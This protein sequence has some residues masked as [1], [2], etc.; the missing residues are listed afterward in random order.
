MHRWIL[1][2]VVAA[3]ACSSAL[4]QVQVTGAWVR[5]TA[6]AQKTTGAYLELTSTRGATLVG[7]E[8]ADAALAEIHEMRMEGNVM[9]MRAVPRLDLPAGTKVELKPGGYHV[10]L[11]GLKKSLAKGESVPL[12]FRIENMDKSV[13]LVDVTA[14]VRAPAA[15]G[16]QSH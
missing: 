5:G 13:T 8:S 16:S 15:G 1:A 9:R 6:G 7:V 12:R 10:M 14:E 4:A 3:A 11:I 2:L